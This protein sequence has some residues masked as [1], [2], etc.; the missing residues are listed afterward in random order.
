M[1]RAIQ[2]AEPFAAQAGHAVRPHPGIVEFDQASG[3]YIPTEELKR[4]NFPAWQKLATGGDTVD[5]TA[6]LVR[7][8]KDMEDVIAAHPGTK[9]GRVLP[10]RGDDDA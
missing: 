4:E 8:V 6:C 3:A 1:R 7:V 9:G 10:W 2:T 5:T